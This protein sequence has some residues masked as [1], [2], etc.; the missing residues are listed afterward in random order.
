MTPSNDPTTR[1]Q[2]RFGVVEWREEVERLRPKGR[3]RAIALRARQTIEA[4]SRNLGWRRCRDEGP[5]ATRLPN[6]LKVYVPVSAEAPS[7]APYGFVFQLQIDSDGS[8]FLNFISFGERHPE[9]AQTRTLYERAHRR[10]HGTYP[11]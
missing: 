3:A 4:D 6:C 11:T 7:E 10:L 1:S 8:L 9:N 5:G 2:I